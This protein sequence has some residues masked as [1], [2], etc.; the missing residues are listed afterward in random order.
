[1]A[2][3]L[4]R[5]A[6]LVEAIMVTGSFK[7]LMDGGNLIIYDA[8]TSVIASASDTLTDQ[9]ALCTITGLNFDTVA[10]NGTITKDSSLWEGTNAATGAA[11]FYRFW[12]S[13]DTYC[14]QGTVGTA[15]CDLNIESISLV[16]T[17]TL[18]INSFALEEPM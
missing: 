8:G 16:D 18:T 11:S 9:V 7:S 2:H 13:T 17:E 5:S 15:G 12:D 4:T 10:P 6:A 1:M 14:L 3:N